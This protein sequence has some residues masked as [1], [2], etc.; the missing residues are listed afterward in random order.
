MHIM[1]AFKLCAFSDE[2]SSSLDGQIKALSENNIP[3]MEIRGVNGKNIAR[4]TKEEAKDIKNKLSASGVS[5]WSIGSPI[6]KVNITDNFDSHLDLFK[7]VLETA[8]TLN[9]ECIR[10]FSFYLPK[11]EPREV[12]IDTVLERLYRFCEV[13]RGSRVTLCHENEKDIFGEDISSCRKIHSS[14]PEIK[15]VFDPANFIQCGVN[16]LEAFEVLSPYVKYM[17]IKDALSD[18]RVVPAGKGIAHL[19]KILPTF[20]KL[21]GEVL[22]IEPHLTVFSGAEALERDG[23]SFNSYV[24]SSGREAFDAAVKSLRELI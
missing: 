18:G 13:A 24:Y 10:L 17:H 2:A 15:A 3:Y 12:Y 23:K 19:D 1:N 14:L 8:H 16:T 21:G 7:A 20:K 22:S 9:A 5:V 6:G 11:G 4:V